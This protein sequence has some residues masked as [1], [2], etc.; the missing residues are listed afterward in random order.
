MRNKILLLLGLF[1]LPLN[2][3]AASGSIK[4][5]ASSSKVT[6][7]NTITVKVTVSSTDTLG[8]WRYGLSYDKSKLS[9][10]SGDT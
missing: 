4:A 6:I 7:G 10:I 9:L 8:S 2:V 1:L 3:F 5:S